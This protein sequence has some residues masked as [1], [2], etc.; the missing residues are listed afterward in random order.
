VGETGPPS[1]G[2]ETSLGGAARLEVGRIGRAHGLRGEVSVTPVS[3]IAQRFAP[4][5]TLWVD[6]RAHVIVSARPNQHR[7]VVRF[8]GVDDRNGADALRGKI[9]EAERLTAPPAGELWV[10]ELIGSEVRDPSGA[11]L[12]RVVAV[13]A[14]PAHDLLVL[15]GGGLVPMVFV[16]SC[17]SGVVVVDPP[18]GLFDL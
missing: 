12:G 10:H 9:V 14:N 7:F 11:A 3:N 13:E 5:S 15:D 1:D 18:E 16:E 8:E 4:G 6:G 17:E 2:A